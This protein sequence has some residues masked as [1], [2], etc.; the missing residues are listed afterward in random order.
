MRARRRRMQQWLLVVGAA[1]AAAGCKPD[2]GAPTSL[3]I[4]PRILAVRGQPAEAPPGDM[5]AYDALAVNAD[6]RIAASPLTWSQCHD[7]KPPAE[8]NAVNRACLDEPDDAGPA[9]T[10]SAPMPAAA[11]MQFGPITPVPPPLTPD[12]IAAGKMQP[13]PLRP[14][15]PDITGGFYQPVR[16]ALT[17][18]QGSATAFA[19]ERI[20]CNL[21]NVPIEATRVY[22]ATYTIN[23]NPTIAALT[24]DPD[25]AAAALLGGAPAMI[26][27]GATVTLEAAWPAEAAESY[28]A[29]D[30]VGRALATRREALRVSWFATAGEFAHDRTGRAEDDPASTTRNTWTAPA[31]AGTVHLWI[32][33]RDSRGGLDFAEATLTVGP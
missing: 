17:A 15:D 24:L 21:A 26:A 1:L 16:V 10:F 27:A 11:C 20:K 3:V 28:P 7:P 5:V 13:P 30:V 14:R 22:N 4:G 19:L 9:P 6:G 12:E 25:G 31:A 32:V 23:Q 33:L 29:W 8:T 18:D 2:L